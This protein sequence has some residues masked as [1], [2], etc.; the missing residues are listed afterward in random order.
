M[1][2]MEVILRALEVDENVQGRLRRGR[3]NIGKAMPLSRRYKTTEES[4]ERWE[5]QGGINQKAGSQG[6]LSTRV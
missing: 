4:E 2:T 3:E 6:Q 1:L 5:R